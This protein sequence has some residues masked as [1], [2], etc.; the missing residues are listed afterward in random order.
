MSATAAPGALSWEDERVRLLDRLAHKLLDTRLIDERERLINELARQETEIERL[1]ETVRDQTKKI[2]DQ[3]T[4]I[5]NQASA[6]Q[7]LNAQLVSVEA[8]QQEAQRTSDKTIS[9]LKQQLTES[10]SAKEEER[11]KHVDEL[12]KLKSDMQSQQHG[13]LLDLLRASE[14]AL[15]AQLAAAMREIQT[16]KSSALSNTNVAPAVQS[17]STPHIVAAPT[18]NDDVLIEEVEDEAPAVAGVISS[19]API[20]DEF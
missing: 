7:K 19:S 10:N 1:R 17:S 12:Q 8:A 20:P 2:E 6:S 9:S 18:G 14:S 15:K 13:E 4:M 16:L 11:R 5:K 3:N